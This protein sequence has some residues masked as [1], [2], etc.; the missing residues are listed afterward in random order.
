MLIEGRTYEVM[1]T[2]IHGQRNLKHDDVDR[3]TIVQGHTP[4]MSHEYS[5]GVTKAEWKTKNMNHPTRFPSGGSC[6]SRATC[7][8][9]HTSC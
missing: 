4:S 3:A 7:I 9:K 1:Q 5:S 6:R 2:G 8:S